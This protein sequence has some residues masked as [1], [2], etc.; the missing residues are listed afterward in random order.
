MNGKDILNS[1]ASPGKYLIVK[2]SPHIFPYL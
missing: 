2:N 1:Y